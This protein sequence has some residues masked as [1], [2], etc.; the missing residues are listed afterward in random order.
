MR[1]L[2]AALLCFSLQAQD[3]PT[4]KETQHRLRLIATRATAWFQSADTIDGSLRRDGHTLHPALLAL[5]MRIE[6]ALEDAQADLQDGKLDGA[7]EQLDRAQA[8]TDRFARHF[9]GD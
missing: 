5:R 9:G 7:N 4:A 3:A 8:W 2:M 1:L 6:A